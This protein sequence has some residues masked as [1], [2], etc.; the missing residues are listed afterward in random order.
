MRTL[1]V[2]ISLCLVACDGPGGSDDAGID[3]GPGTDSGRELP[4]AGPVVP[5]EWAPIGSIAEDSGEGSFRFGAASAATQIEDMNPDV[6]WFV[7]TQPPPEGLGEG[8]DPIGDA[9]R[10][11]SLAIEDIALMEEMNLD[12]YRF[13]VEW[14]RV[15]PRR[16]EVA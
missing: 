9:V 6:D 14:A 5:I 13:S 3:A 1:A 16:G 8:T 7:W 11:F 4:D 15:E 12:S 2:L 10:G